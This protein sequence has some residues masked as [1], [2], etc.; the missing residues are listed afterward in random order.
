MC[1]GDCGSCDLD[2]TMARRNR[3]V[4]EVIHERERQIAVDGANTGAMD[5]TNTRNDWIAYINAYT[6][7]AAE[8]VF[9]NERERQTFRENMVKAA[10]LCLAAIE[11]HDK[12]Y[13]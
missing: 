13:C 3:I 4:G 9:R 7:R 6:G 2:D 11:A 12:G 10:A 1:S 5:K 8:K